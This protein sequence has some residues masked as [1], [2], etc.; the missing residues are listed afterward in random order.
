MRSRRY[1]RIPFEK[2]WASIHHPGGSC[3][4]SVESLSLGGGAGRT[5][6]RA[7]N[8]TEGELEI[9]VGLRKLRASVLL[10]PAA[11]KM[12]FEIAAIS[13]EDRARLRQLLTSRMRAK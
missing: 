11:Y 3:T 2:L 10:Y 4:V 13:L 6:S 1:Q 7:Q 8:A 5:T 9:A 12:A